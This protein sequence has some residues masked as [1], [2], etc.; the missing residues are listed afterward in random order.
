MEPDRK[1]LS[2]ISDGL[3]AE[4]RVSFVTTVYP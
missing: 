4:L 3:V 2:L 1:A